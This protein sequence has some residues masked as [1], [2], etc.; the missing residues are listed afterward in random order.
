MISYFIKSLI[1]K[2]KSHTLKEAGSCPF[3]GNTYDYCTRCTAMI[4]QQ[5]VV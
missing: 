3:T 4:P 2:V 5:E 1:C